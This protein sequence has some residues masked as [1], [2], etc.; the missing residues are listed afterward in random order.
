MISLYY[1]RLIVLLLQSQAVS[2][3]C[4]TYNCL[5]AFDLRARRLPHQSAPWQRSLAT[6]CAIMSMHTQFRHGH[7][8]SYRCRYTDIG[9]QHDSTRTLGYV[10]YSWIVLG[11][12]GFERSLAM[13]IP[14]SYHPYYSV[15]EQIIFNLFGG[16]LIIPMQSQGL[17]FIFSS[18]DK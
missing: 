11:R 13:M 2:S 7:R 12:F 15:E 14:G 3:H 4:G 1:P 9:L 10:L 18:Q 6:A 16:T 17:T 5:E 8:Y